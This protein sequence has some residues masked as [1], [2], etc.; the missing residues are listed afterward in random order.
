MNMHVN[1]A[2]HTFITSKLQHGIKKFLSY[3]VGKAVLL[4]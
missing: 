4:K 2:A 1:E 3:D